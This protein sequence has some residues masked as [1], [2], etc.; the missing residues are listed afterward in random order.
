MC[1]FVC[2]L[3]G[4]VP[5]KSN[6]VLVL[7]NGPSFGGVLRHTAFFMFI[8]EANVLK[9]WDAGTALL[10]LAWKEMFDPFTPDTFQPRLFNVPMLVS[11]LRD[12]SSRAAVSPDRWR[13]H[14]EF[15]QHELA[16][17]V[18]T[19][20]QFLQGMQYYASMCRR[21]ITLQNSAEVE[22]LAKT[23]LHYEEIYEENA[24]TML[25][26][27]ARNL[28][29]EK[30]TA[31]QSLRRI[32]TMAL[33]SGFGND[34]FGELLEEKSFQ[35]SALDWAKRLLLAF[36]GAKQPKQEFDCIVPVFGVDSRLFVKMLK[37]KAE[38]QP[39]TPKNLP[40][41]PDKTLKG[42]NFF[43]IGSINAS[44]ATE[45]AKQA[46]RLLR[47]TLDILAFYDSSQVPTFGNTAWVGRQKEG[48]IVTI[49]GQSLRRLHARRHSLNLTKQALQIPHQFL[50][51]RILNA[52]EHLTLAKTNSAFRAKLVNLWSALECLSIP[53]NSSESVIGRVRDT[54]VP[55]VVWRRVDKITRYIA[56]TMTKLRDAGL[57][58][59]FG[60]I[61][62][63]QGIIA[64][65]EVLL[66]LCKPLEHPDIKKLYAAI[67]CHPLL[68]N[69]IFGLR[70]T[71]SE[72]RHLLS[73]LRAS[74]ER[75]IWHLNRIYRARN[76]IV[77]EGHEDP[78]VPFLVD[79]LQYY[80]SLTI[81]R[82][83][84]GMSSHP[85]WDVT[86]SITHWRNR[87]AYV[88]QMLDEQPKTLQVRDFFPLPMRFV[89][90]QIWDD[91]L[92]KSAEPPSDL[93]APLPDSKSI[94]VND[95]NAGA[96]SNDG[97]SPG[98]S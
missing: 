86:T 14:L 6:L 94:A 37:F 27:S 80:L 89:R 46:V 79:N 95:A 45:A 4:L 28:P 15:V 20:S 60:P 21:L 81:S 43:K 48:R 90:H 98:K 31:V 9:N 74:S 30:D 56:A 87:S 19:E 91:P 52:L 51:G 32:A 40:W 12:I 68:K 53:G 42:A 84:H 62:S 38:F 18:S 73:D 2:E 17:V 24:K 11:E 85:G 8:P 26:E 41:K 97:K 36:E 78:V 69:R 50:T 83:L 65:E 75:T 96:N 7:T 1:D 82:I 35:L 54:T 57:A 49:A 10:I 29:K 59:D 33:R 64:A 76:L 67:D 92:P 47:P 77:H 25:L 72:P 44:T 93:T 34:E 66:A 61:F 70:K 71:F 16:A 58:G 55:I 63:S 39:Q 88:I 5:Y 3:T 22:S 23:L 13:S